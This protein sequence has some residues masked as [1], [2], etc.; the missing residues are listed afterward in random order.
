MSKTIEEQ[1]V[2]YDVAYKLKE[3]G[4]NEPCIS[5]YVNKKFKLKIYLNKD[6]NLN[7]DFIIGNL[8]AT[9]LYQQVFDWFED[10]HKL[11]SSIRIGFGNPIW[12]D[13]MIEAMDDRTLQIEKNVWLNY[14]DLGNDIFGDNKSPTYIEENESFDT[15]REA[16]IA[17]INKLIELCQEV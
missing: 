16:Q 3:L 14:D 4:F 10:K 1:F 5:Y 17:C 11:Y 15:K 8:V 7:S 9:P 12:Y 2:S 13:Y 6:Y